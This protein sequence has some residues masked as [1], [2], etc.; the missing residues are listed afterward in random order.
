MICFI[1]IE[2]N[3][4]FLHA[5]FLFQEPSP[6][7]SLKSILVWLYTTYLCVSQVFK[8]LNLNVPTELYSG[9]CYKAAQGALGWGG[10]ALGGYIN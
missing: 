9:P 10:V 2:Q 4:F 7:S 8:K 3:Y 5:A 6:S 1:M